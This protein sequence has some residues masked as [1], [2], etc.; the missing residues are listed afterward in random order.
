MPELT[1]DQLADIRQRY[2]TGHAALLHRIGAAHGISA[3][4][5][6]AIVQGRPWRYLA[7]R[8]AGPAIGDLFD[9]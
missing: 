3:E 7:E 2:A 5:A 1:D 4:C 9:D 6:E 8:S